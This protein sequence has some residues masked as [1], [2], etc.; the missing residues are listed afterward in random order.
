MERRYLPVVLD[1]QIG[2][3]G[4]AH[5]ELLAR[6]EDDFTAAERAPADLDDRLHP[7]GSPAFW[8]AHSSQKG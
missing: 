8:R 3:L 7:A 2:A 6:G 5:P 4:A 1:H